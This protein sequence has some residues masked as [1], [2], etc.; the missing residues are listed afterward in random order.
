MC[1]A[2]VPGALRGQ[3]KVSDSLE[4]EV[5]CELPSGC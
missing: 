1:A 2:W 4:L 5:I 3:K